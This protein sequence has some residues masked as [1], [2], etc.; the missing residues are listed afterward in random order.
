MAQ[1]SS[2][3][4]RTPK[5][6]KQQLNRAPKRSSKREKNNGRGRT[7]RA[8]SLSQSLSLSLSLSH[9]LSPQVIP[10]FQALPGLYVPALQELKKHICTKE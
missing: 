10:F 4:K 3:Q 7:G 5:G 2:R 1:F 6:G 8:L 9:T